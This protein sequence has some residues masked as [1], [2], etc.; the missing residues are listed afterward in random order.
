[1]LKS[2]T[3]GI[4]YDPWFDLWAIDPI[5]GNQIEILSF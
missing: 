2:F 4:I 5:R 1:M 3:R